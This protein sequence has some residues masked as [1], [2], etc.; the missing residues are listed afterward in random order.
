L[1]CPGSFRIV[2]LAASLGLL[3]LTS[4]QRHRPDLNQKSERNFHRCFRR[5]GM[6]VHPV[7]IEGKNSARNDFIGGGRAGQAVPNHVFPL[8][9]TS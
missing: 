4:Q 6:V 1:R 9:L 7:D 3:I 5:G 8:D 2:I